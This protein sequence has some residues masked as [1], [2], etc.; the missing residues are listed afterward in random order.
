LGGLILLELLTA[1]VLFSA[2]ARGVWF[3]GAHFG[4][5]C[6]FQERW[7]FPCP[8]CGM[9]RSVL[10]TLHGH[11]ATALA[12]NPAGPLWVAAALALAATLVA[13][14]RWVRPVALA[15]GSAFALVAAAHWL[16]L[17]LAS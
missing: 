2:D 12:V 15:A 5:A 1:A 9:T 7:G 10:L 8:T 4:S 3:L 13:A 6:Y 14:K 16:R 17:M 11:F